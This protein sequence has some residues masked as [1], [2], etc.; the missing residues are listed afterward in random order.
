MAKR[1]VC[2]EDDES[3]RQ[4]VL[5]ALKSG[6]YEAAGC[7]ER[8]ELFD[9]LERQETDLILLDIMLPG[10]DGLAI[11]QELRRNPHYCHIPVIMLTAK[12]SEYDRVRGLDLGADDYIPKPFGIMELLSRIRAV[13]RRCSPQEEVSCL[14]VGP[15]SLDYEKRQVTVSGEPCR[16]T[17]KE[18]ELLHYLMEN[19]G[20]VLSRDKI[21]EKVWGFDFEGES[22]TVDMHIKTLRKKL[23]SCGVQDFIQT[24]RSVG[25]KVEGS[26]Q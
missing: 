8:A 24:V 25:Y 18:F 19:K 4:L 7:E 12:T 20:I 14:T 23:E 3:I 5:Y 2:V 15:V 6:G 16:L 22:R 26:L 17:Y 10:Q 1:I 13:L 21:M 11:L 9:L